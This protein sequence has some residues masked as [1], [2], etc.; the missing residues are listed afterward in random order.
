MGFLNDDL[1]HALRMCLAKVYEH[2]PCAVGI[3]LVFGSYEPGEVTPF[4]IAT[5]GEK[6]L[7]RGSEELGQN[8]EPLTAVANAKSLEREHGVKA[9]VALHWLITDRP[10]LDDVVRRMLSK[11]EEEL[12]QYRQPP[13]TVEEL[14]IITE[15]LNAPP[16]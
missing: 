7:K 14:V 5:A 12:P 2:E 1:E 11:I 16:S 13:T 15:F 3:F 8:F 4:G 10:P 6:K 9:A